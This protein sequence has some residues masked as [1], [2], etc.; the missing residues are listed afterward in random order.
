[1]KNFN[2]F[3]L[4]FQNKI[5]LVL[6]N[7]YKNI[8]FSV[9]EISRDSERRRSRTDTILPAADSAN[10]A[11][12]GYEPVNFHHMR[13]NNNK[14]NSTTDVNY[15]SPEI[16]ANLPPNTSSGYINNRGSKT[17]LL[18]SAS[19]P[20]Q[21]DNIS[22]SSTPRGSKSSAV[23]SSA[24]L[25]AEACR[26]FERGGRIGVPTLTIPPPPPLSS[27]SSS[28]HQSAEPQKPPAPAAYT[29]KPAVQ[30][31]NSGGSIGSGSAVSNN[32]VVRLPPPP[33]QAPPPGPQ[34]QQQTG[35]GPPQVQ[36]AGG[37]IYSSRTSSQV[38]FEIC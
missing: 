25:V 9:E 12:N 36:A 19:S 4:S 37:Q 13:M 11:N 7:Q 8:P 5:E 16:G 29:T 34:Y 31:K 26:D 1:M 35:V 33:Y 32:S 21:T 22:A 10:S 17:S 30:K 3:D 15:K 6:E 14:P 20:Q 18:S 38:Y 24:T 27:D 2:R 23:L 28:G